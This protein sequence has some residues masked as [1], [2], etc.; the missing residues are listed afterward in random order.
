LRRQREAVAKFLGTPGGDGEPSPAAF[1]SSRDFAWTHNPSASWAGWSPS[2]L[3]TRFQPAEQ[4]AFS[5]AQVRNL[6]LKWALR[7]R[8]GHYGFRRAYG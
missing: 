2:A 6:K 5:L 1:C 8:S 4:A 7:I 3:N